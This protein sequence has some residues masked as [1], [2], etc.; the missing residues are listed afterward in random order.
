MS[1][2]TKRFTK[3]DNGFVCENCGFEVMPLLKTSRNHC[4]RCLCSIHIDVNPGDRASDCGGLLV[5]VFCE[6]DTKKGFVITHKCKKCGELRKN[7][8]AIKT[9]AKETLPDSQYDD[10]NLLIRLT[11]SDYM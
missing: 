4:P 5:P 1:T 2:E 10:Q 3:N 9:S 8:A 7:R 6:P 11:V